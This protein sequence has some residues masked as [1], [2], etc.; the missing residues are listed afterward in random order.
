MVTPHGAGVLLGVSA[1][2]VRRWVLAGKIPEAFMT[3]TGRWKI[4]VEAVEEMKRRY[5]P[6]SVRASLEDAGLFGAENPARS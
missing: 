5:M 1:D 3:P 2:T 6:P 4:P